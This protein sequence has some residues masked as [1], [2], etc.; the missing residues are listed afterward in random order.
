M[1]LNNKRGEAF[2]GLCII[3]A[4]VLVAIFAFGYPQYN[5]WSRGKKGEAELKQAESNRKIAT[6]EA[7]A[8]QE[9]AEALAQ[10]AII[11]AKGIAE[12]NRIIGNSLENNPKYLNYLWIQSLL[13][14]GNDVIYVPTE[15]NIPIMEA[16]RATSKQKVTPRESVY[17]NQGDT[18]AL[19]ERPAH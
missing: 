14:G 17:A 18:I 9:S 12:A 4:I 3:I 2:I 5:V 11:E 19:P 7:L 1:V 10:A 15:A 13:E 6:L 16:G 8:K